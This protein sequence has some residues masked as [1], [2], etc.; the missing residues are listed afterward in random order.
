MTAPVVAST[1]AKSHRTS[2]G[3]SHTVNLPT[4]ITAGD[5]LYMFI[6]AASNSDSV[7]TGGLGDWTLVSL[8]DLGDLY[9]SRFY[10]RTADGNEVSTVVCTT[11][12]SIRSSGV[13]YRVTGAQDP[14]V[15]APQINWTVSGGTS[16]TVPQ[17]PELNPT[18]GEKDYLVIAFLGKERSNSTSGW[19]SG[20]TNTGSNDLAIAGS[21]YASL[22]VTAASITPGNF[23]T[24]NATQYSVATVAVHPAT[25]DPKDIYPVNELISG[26]ATT[27]GGN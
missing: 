3:T 15:Q 13:V 10:R 14:G 6:H 11:S 8:S 2:N 18:G 24:S 4:G 23:T 26:Q 5:E 27:A 1:P 22:A 16:S 9:R 19:P 21:A 17:P 20:Y 12:A 7:I 25:A